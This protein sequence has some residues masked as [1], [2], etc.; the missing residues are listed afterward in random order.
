MSSQRRESKRGGS[1]EAATRIAAH[2]L[3]YSHCVL[4]CTHT[5]THTVTHTHK[6]S[7]THPHIMK[8]IGTNPISK[9][10]NCAFALKTHE[11]QQK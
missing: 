6:Q 3:H 8:L 2:K 10:I 9:C 11:R 7:P 5:D 1:Q 4:L